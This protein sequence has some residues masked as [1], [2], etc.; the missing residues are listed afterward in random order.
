MYQLL[1]HGDPDAKAAASSSLINGTDKKALDTYA[2]FR[3]T[4]EDQLAPHIENHAR[5]LLDGAEGGEGHGDRVE[6]Y[7][8]GIMDT[9]YAS[10]NEF[11]NMGMDINKISRHPETYRDMAAVSAKYFDA[12][13]KAIAHNKELGWFG[14]KKE[15]PNMTNYML[16]TISV[17]AP[18]TAERM[19]LSIA[20]QQNP[21]ADGGTIAKIAKATMDEWTSLKTFMD[22]APE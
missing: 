8:A 6:L 13:R 21:E 22:E 10:S 11:A 3:K 12:K 7:K 20:F 2:K 14:T 1:L 5:L 17:T 15:I 9:L 18:K 4:V 16:K 19:A